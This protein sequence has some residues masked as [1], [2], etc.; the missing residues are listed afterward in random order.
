MF[1]MFITFVDIKPTSTKLL[2]YVTKHDFK[3][4]SRR[5]VYMYIYCARKHSC[6]LALYFIQSL[7]CFYCSSQ[8]SGRY[9]RINI[10]D[11]FTMT[12]IGEQQPSI[13]KAHIFAEDLHIALC[14]SSLQNIASQQHQD[15]KS[16]YI[17]VMC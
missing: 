13:K 16:I 8:H 1:K 3:T 15:E 7:N 17:C 12:N 10:H 2:L 9:L 5:A 11:A 6:I 14:A 4:F